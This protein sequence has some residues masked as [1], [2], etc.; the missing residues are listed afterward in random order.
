MALLNQKLIMWVL[1]FLKQLEA[2]NKLVSSSSMK[3]YL[4]SFLEV[5]HL[6]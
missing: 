3:F 2:I 5:V 6:K 1:W 4:L